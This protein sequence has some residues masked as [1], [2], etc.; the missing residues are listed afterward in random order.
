VDELIGLGWR[1]VIRCAP[2]GEDGIL[3]QAADGVGPTSSARSRPAPRT[4][5]PAPRPLIAENVGDN[6][7][8]L[9]RP[10]A[11]DLFETTRS[12]AVSGPMLLGVCV[13]SDQTAVGAYPLVLGAVAISPPIIGKFAVR[14]R[15]GNVEPPLFYPGS[16]YRGVIAAE[17]F[18]SSHQSGSW[19]AHLQ[20][21]RQA[22]RQSATGTVLHGSGS[23]SRRCFMITR[24]HR[25]AILPVK[26]PAAA[27]Q[28]RAHAT[29]TSPG[30][31]KGLQATALLAWCS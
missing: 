9:R 20:G 25:D 15:A 21:R 4:R 23:Q 22:A 18:I 14:S 26:K 3:T 28:D 2:R 7:G 30:L 27:S 16:R 24:Y 19:T 6:V 10:M 5:S 31:E 1:L 12:P 11:A 29:N 17:G 8:G 13:T